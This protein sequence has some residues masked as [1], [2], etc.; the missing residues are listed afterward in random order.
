M[1]KWKDCGQEGDLKRE[2]MPLKKKGAI[3][4]TSRRGHGGLNQKIWGE[5]LLN[6]KK[7]SNR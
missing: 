1:K 6:S 5:S 4:G 3:G 7:R 2:T